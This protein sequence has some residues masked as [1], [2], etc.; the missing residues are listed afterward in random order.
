MG[1][2]G[3]CPGDKAERDGYRPVEEETACALSQYGGMMWAVLQ[4]HTAA[5]SPEACL[6]VVCIFCDGHLPKTITRTITHVC[7]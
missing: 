1:C 3:S 7:V 5:V 4:L 2:L 6:F